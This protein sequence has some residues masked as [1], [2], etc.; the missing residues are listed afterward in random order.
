MDP[1]RKMG[2]SETITFTVAEPEPFPTV[3]VVAASVVTVF[4]V[5]A[6]LLVYFK[7]R[8]H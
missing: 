4:V 7:K 5:G 6:G 1:L 8:N 2:L 3:P